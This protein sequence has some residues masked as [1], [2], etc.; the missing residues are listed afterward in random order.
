MVKPNT[1][2]KRENKILHQAKGEKNATLTFA[3]RRVNKACKDVV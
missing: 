3:N 1:E 2:L